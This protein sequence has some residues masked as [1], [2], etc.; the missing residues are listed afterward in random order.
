MLRED[1]HSILLKKAKEEN[2]SIS[3]YIKKILI[4]SGIIEQLSQESQENKQEG[5]R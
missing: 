1:V 5:K 2:I 3:D 4:E